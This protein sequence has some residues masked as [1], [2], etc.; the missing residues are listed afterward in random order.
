MENNLKETINVYIYGDVQ[1]Y[2]NIYDTYVC[3]CVYIY[4]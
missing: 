2:I 1:M 3:V 4:N